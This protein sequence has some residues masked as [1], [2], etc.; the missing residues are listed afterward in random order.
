MDC[1]QME[2]KPKQL[3]PL[4]CAICWL[5]FVWLHFFLLSFSLAAFYVKSFLFTADWPPSLIY[6]YRNKARFCSLIIFFFL[7]RC[8][9]SETIFHSYDYLQPTYVTSN[10]LPTAQFARIHVTWSKYKRFW[11]TSNVRCIHTKHGNYNIKTK[12]LT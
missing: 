12:T 3:L 10:A 6:V 1:V 9:K 4:I 8:A 5:Y 11:Q 2:T 7:F